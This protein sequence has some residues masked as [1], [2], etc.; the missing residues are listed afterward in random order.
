MADSRL[1]KIPKKF[2]VK[3]SLSSYGTTTL[4]IVKK[5]MSECVDE[6]RERCKPMWTASSC[7]G[8]TAHLACAQTL[9]LKNGHSV[10]PCCGAPFYGKRPSD[11]HGWI[12]VKID[13]AGCLVAENAKD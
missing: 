13:L 9:M 5:C 7:C 3:L 11:A 10:C 2:A 6:E 1:V 4:H 12:Q 8:M